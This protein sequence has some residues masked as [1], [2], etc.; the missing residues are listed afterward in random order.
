MSAVVQEQRRVE[1]LTSSDQQ[2][3]HPYVLTLEPNQE[4]RMNPILY[5]MEE[6][7]AQQLEDG[8]SSHS[9]SCHVKLLSSC[10]CLG[11]TAR[12]RQRRSLMLLGAFMLLSVFA[13][14]Y[15]FVVTKKKEDDRTKRQ[16]EAAARLAYYRDRFV[17]LRTALG[18]YSKP[19]LFYDPNSAQSKALQWLV[20]KD[21]ILEVQ[22]ITQELD[23]VVDS[24]NTNN[25][26]FRLA[27]RYAYMVLYFECGGQDWFSLVEAPTTKKNI[28]NVAGAAAIS[29]E[30]TILNEQWIRM[31][32][33]E[34]LGC[35]C[36]DQGQLTNLTLRA[37]NLV[38]K[39]PMEIG[40]L[41]HLI[42][43]N[44][45]YNSLRG[46][47]PMTPKTGLGQLA[48]LE[49][50]TLEYNQL[51]GTISPEIGQLTQL[52]GLYLGN[53]RLTGAL[54]F[55]AMTQLKQLETIQIYSNYDLSGPLM[56]MATAAPWSQLKGVSAI[57]TRV[58]G[59]LP[60]DIALLSNLEYIQLT[61][62]EVAG[63]FPDGI[64]QLAKLYEF[65]AGSA[66]FENFT[67]S[68]S[69]GNLT[70]LEYLGVFG[71]GI[72]GTLPTELGLLTNLKFLV[73]GDSSVTGT[74]PTEIGLLTNL[75][76]LDFSNSKY[77]GTIPEEY[78]NLKSLEEFVLWGSPLTG[79]VPDSICSFKNLDVIRY[80][81][82]VTCNCCSYDCQRQS[83]KPKNNT[84]AGTNNN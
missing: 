7:P 77:K 83:K 84:T 51:W 8:S 19:F 69:I 2:G 76:G 16:N 66:Q 52:K 57:D 4:L 34:F 5:T 30:L 32:E 23:Q 74:L 71:Q 31:H 24:N 58:T 3:P 64:Y 47:L 41:T 80:P 67:F 35:S 21:E 44:L 55:E 15:T 14:V 11:Q 25:S 63:S 62:T 75:L 81:C 78:G 17:A 1:D 18:N 43:L 60:D 33:C 56:E 72:Q 28:A 10:G 73:V 45:G 54:P 61:D 6:A 26:A 39:I 49:T 59:K 20:F 46:T 50:L 68:P 48:H 13:L 12:T 65:S 22:Q 9:S 82:G 53:N 27:Q 29:N 40:L 79:T 37:E 38:G 42:V 70:K 36:N